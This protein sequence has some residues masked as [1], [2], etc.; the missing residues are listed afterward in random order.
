V[1]TAAIAPSALAGLNWSTRQSQIPSSQFRA[2][3]IEPVRPKQEQYA[4]TV[5]VELPQ[6][7][8]PP[9]E[10]D[11][12]VYRRFH[13]GEDMFVEGGDVN[14][15]DKTAHCRQERSAEDSLLNDP[16][17][18]VLVDSSDPHAGPKARF[19]HPGAR[20]VETDPRAFRLLR[21]SQLELEPVSP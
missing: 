20:T 16:P 15:S 1:L 3:G 18:V 2:N 10:P 9:W 19:R 7:Q 5:I 17:A 12:P 8:V 11:T 14:V 6:S 13:V 21:R 4:L